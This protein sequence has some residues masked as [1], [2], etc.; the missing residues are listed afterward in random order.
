MK[1]SL[2]AIAILTPALFPDSALA[3]TGSLEGHWQNGAMEIVIGPCGSTLC[4]TVTKASAKQQE[5]AES[6]SGTQLLGSK[7]IDNIEPAGPESW[8]A[9]I[10][11]ASRNTYAR[12]TIEEIGTDQLAVRGCVAFICKTTHWS[13]SP[14]NVQDSPPGG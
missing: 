2:L 8:N 13:R 1:R 7:I 14:T 9:E 4:G 11:V 6:G 3:Q 5:K 12:G 10:F